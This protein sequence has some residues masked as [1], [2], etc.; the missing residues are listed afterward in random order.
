MPQT[1]FD[2][3]F[4]G[5]R[6]GNP[7][8]GGGGTGTQDPAPGSYQGEFVAGQITPG[9]EADLIEQ[10]EGVRRQEENRYTQG[11]DLAS[12]AYRQSQ[13]ALS[14]GVDADLLFSRASDA[15]GA[16]SREGMAALRRSL[17]GRGINPNSGAAGGLLSRLLFERQGALVGRVG[18]SRLRT[19]GR[20]SRT[21]R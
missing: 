18:T 10:A 14:Q 15:V 6:R 1:F 19:S 3:L 16:R 13:A 4:P 12:Q 5:G 7:F 20:G 11:V 9:S 2:Q 8:G 17:G 21:R